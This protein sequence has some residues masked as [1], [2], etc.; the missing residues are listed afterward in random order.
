A[1]RMHDIARS[2]SPAAHAVPAA[3]GRARTVWAPEALLRT[4]LDEAVDTLVR[5]AGRSA[6][7]DGARARRRAEDGAR[8]RRRSARKAPAVDDDHTPWEDR[9]LAAL[10]GPDDSFTTA[11]F[12]ERTLI[13]DLDAWS[14]P[15]LGASDRLRAC[16]RLE[17][18]EH[19]DKPF[20]L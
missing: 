17:L 20:V 11:G 10:E 5:N 8:A 16:F 1:S 18:P 15:V 7:G 14:R 4:F 2:M 13:D 6:A 12:A 9:W 3:A 19:D